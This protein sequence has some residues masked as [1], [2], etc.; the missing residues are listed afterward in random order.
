MSEQFIQWR[1]LTGRIADKVQEYIDERK[2]WRKDA[3]LRIDG[4]DGDV[5]LLENVVE[6]AVD[7]IP[8]AEVRPVAAFVTNDRSGTQVPDIEA[9]EEFAGAWFDLRRAD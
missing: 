4:P 5:E 1:K 6:D 9:I 8:S 7:G 3:V 2:L